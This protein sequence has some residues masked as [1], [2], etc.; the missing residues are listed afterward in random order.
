MWLKCLWHPQNAIFTHHFAMSTTT[1]C[2]VWTK[3]K[4][5]L[6]HFLSLLPCECDYGM[7]PCGNLPKGC[8]QPVLS[9]CVSAACCF[10]AESL[11]STVSSSVRLS[12]R[13]DCLVS[14]SSKCC[15]T[16]FSS[17]FTDFSSL[18]KSAQG[19][20]QASWWSTNNKLITLDVWWCTHKL[21]STW[22]IFYSV[23]F[24]WITLSLDN[25]TGLKS[26]HHS[27]SKTW[28]N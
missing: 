20:K 7:W 14:N 28:N 1:P 12:N 2:A 18:W 23:K 13:R 3:L 25:I 17:R 16:S 27:S 11:C 5:F 22:S 4:N 8:T 19:E 15:S 21:L 24:Q 10:L 9:H 26:R 6:P